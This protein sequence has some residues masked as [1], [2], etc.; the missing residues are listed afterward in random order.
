DANLARLA[1]RSL[2]LFDELSPERALV[3]LSGL[4][5]LARTPERFGPLASS[6]RAVGTPHVIETPEQ[7]SARL[8]GLTTRGWHGLYT[9]SGGVLDIHALTEV[10]VRA[11]RGLGVEIRCGVGAV[12]VTTNDARV[13][14]V[15]TAS[16]ERVA[17]DDVIFAAGAWNG[18]LGES[19]GVPLPL[20]PVRRHLALLEPQ[21]VFP[22]GVPPV[23]SL[24]DEVYF[25]REGQRV[26]ASPCD[27]TA[28][29]TRV[30]QPELEC[31]AP[32]G[33]KLGGIDDSL[34]RARVARYWACL[35][36]FAPDRRPVI[37]SDPRVSGLHWLAGLGGFGMTIGVAAGELLAQSFLGRQPPPELAPERLLFGRR[38]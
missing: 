36:T 38:G 33:S 6:A 26:L 35:R 5:L 20:T 11:S 2:A 37:G 27:E 28:W 31:L 24:D 9:P 29:S 15:Q 22:S 14:G 16:L 17:A 12:E 10:L 19:A 32:L 18:E 7:V 4:L 1:L 25:R 3:E 30:P 8:S 34:G 21:R 23:W 13:V